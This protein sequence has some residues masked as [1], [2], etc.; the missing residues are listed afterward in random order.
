MN[1][2]LLLLIPAVVIL[3]AAGAVTW[4]YTG[5]LSDSKV[6]VFAR[7]PLPAAIVGKKLLFAQ[8][9]I[10]RVELSKKL[11]NAQ[12]ADDATAPEDLR[13]Q[14]YDRLVDAKKLEAIAG[15]KKVSVTSDQINQEYKDIVDQYGEGNEA[16]FADDLRQSYGLNSS[17]F[18]DKVLRLDVLQSNLAIWFNGQESLNQ[19]AYQLAGDLKAKLQNGESFESVAAAYTQD[20]AMKNFAGDSGFLPFTD[21]LPEYQAALKDAK[22][23]DLKLV[24]G[25]SG[26]LLIKVLE[27]DNN[28]DN[29]ADRIHLQQIFVETSSFADWYQKESSDIKVTKLLKL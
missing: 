26:L 9:L 25:R 22:P 8:D 27:R 29:G 14:V 13:S 23:G 10:D 4:L 24:P 15:E 16:K 12:G 18:K 11:A 20:E 19:K 3:L 17:Q 1:K 7:V 5:S 28:G 2:K 21:L 6:K